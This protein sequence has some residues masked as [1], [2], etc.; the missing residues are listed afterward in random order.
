MFK[1]GLQYFAFG[2][3]Y[4]GQ[5]RWHILYLFCFHTLHCVASICIS[6]LKTAKSSVGGT[7]GC[8][9]PGRIITMASRTFCCWNGQITR[10]RQHCSHGEVGTTCY[11]VWLRSSSLLACR[12]IRSVTLQYVGMGTEQW[13]MLPFVHCIMMDIS[14]INCLFA[15]TNNQCKSIVYMILS[16]KMVVK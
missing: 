16:V 10:W 1:S 4:I 14:E 2:T 13:V 6:D 11:H 9:P 3:C 5:D 12:R 7:L 15:F 8:Y